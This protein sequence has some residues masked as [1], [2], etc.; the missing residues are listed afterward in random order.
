MV[1]EDGFLPRPFAIAGRRLVYSVGITYLAVTA[2]L[3]LLVFRGITDRLIPL[4][5]IGAFLTFTL[6]QAGMVVHWRGELHSNQRGNKHAHRL[7]LVINAVGSL[8]TGA[9][10]IIII[11]AKFVEGAWITLV[12]IPCVILL[13]KQICR[14]YERL[15]ETLSNARPVTLHGVNPPVVIV[16]VGDCNRLTSKAVSFAF[17]ISPDVIGLHLTH[18]T[19][20]G[21]DEQQQ[22]LKQKWHDMV[23]V[24]ARRAG[25]GEPRLVITAAQY[26]TIEEPVLKLVDQL[27][28]KMSSRQVA[29]LIPEVVRTHWYQ[30]LLHSDYASHLRAQ[31]LRRGG[32]RLTVIN[33][34]LHIEDDAQTKAG[35]PELPKN[36]KA[37]ARARKLETS[38]PNR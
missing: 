4:F 31:L 38:H 20:P 21:T 34:P 7:H 32:T 3:L 2:G 6:S 10:L 13:L 37:G 18:L 16:A 29:V 12:A 15:G 23:V 28:R 27:E 11:I 36:A 30:A 9:A 26:R 14:Y 8:A 25:L 22:Q 33:V 19:G 35:R 1:A 17:S 5:A 24:P